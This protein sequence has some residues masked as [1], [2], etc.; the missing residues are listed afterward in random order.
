MNIKKISA[1]F[2]CAATLFATSSFAV[3]N[4]FTA[5]LSAGFDI[6]AHNTA[7]FSG[8]WFRTI[9]TVCRV[10]SPNNDSNPVSIFALNNRTIVN[11]T[12][13]LEGRQTSM[14]LHAGDRIYFELDP[15]GKFTVSNNG[16]QL[17]NLLCN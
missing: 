1:V 17:I 5:M 4:D 10:R 7:T 13:L 8:S 2:V 15:R 12:I 9:S 16:D 14:E 11:N 6:P 3:N